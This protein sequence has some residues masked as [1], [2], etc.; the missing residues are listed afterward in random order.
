MRKR[1]DDRFG[2]GIALAGQHCRAVRKRLEL[3]AGGRC[4]QELRLLPRRYLPEIG[5]TL[6]KPGNLQAEEQNKGQE[7]DRERREQIGRAPLRADR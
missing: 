5:T 1:G 4:A 2:V 3:L 7:P 6:Q